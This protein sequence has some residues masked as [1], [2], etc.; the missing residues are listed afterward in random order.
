M[1]VTY[2]KLLWPMQCSTMFAYDR[3]CANVNWWDIIFVNYWLASNAL[4]DLLMLT[5]VLHITTFTF[6]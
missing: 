2:H 6:R 4:P 3:H 5:F 1:K